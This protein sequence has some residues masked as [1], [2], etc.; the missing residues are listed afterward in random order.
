MFLIFTLGSSCIVY[1]KVKF[2]E[3]FLYRAKSRDGGYDLGQDK[4]GDAKVTKKD[5]DNTRHHRL[6]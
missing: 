5:D 2:Q 6:L 3:G 1:F 4:I